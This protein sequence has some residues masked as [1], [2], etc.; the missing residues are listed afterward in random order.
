MKI[1]AAGDVDFVAGDR[2]D[3]GSD[4]G[5]DAKFWGPEGIAVD[6]A[7]NLYVADTDNSTIRKIAPDGF[8][9]TLGGKPEYAGSTDGTGR[10]AR[11]FSPS[12]VA[13]DSAGNIYVADTFNN[14]IRIG[15][16]PIPDVAIIDNATVKV[17]V[18]RQLGTSTPSATSWQWTV[19]RR[20]AGSSASLS[21]SSIRNPTFIPDIAD[22]YQFRLVAN[23]ASGTSITTVSLGN[24]PVR[25]RVVR[26]GR[27]P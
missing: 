18:A 2:S 8:V 11:F 14:A 16:T 4:D 10:D 25:R 3:E 21:S 22:L 17:G 9:T 23:N 5:Y 24:S 12:G 6:N 13:V 20:P 26:R 15:T 7:G 1:T 27:L 19:I